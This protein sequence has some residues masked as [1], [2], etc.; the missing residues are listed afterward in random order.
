MSNT[1]L[2]Q[3]QNAF[4]ATVFAH[5]APASQDG[6]S[7]YRNNLVL[8]HQ[9]SLMSVFPHTTELLAD[10]FKAA[11]YRYLN[12]YGKVH[13][14]WAEI[15]ADFAEFLTQQP[16]LQRYPYISDLAQYEWLFHQANRAPRKVLQQRSIELLQQQDWQTLYLDLAPG[17]GLCSSDF[18]VVAMTDTH[19]YEAHFTP[20]PDPLMW[21]CWRPAL[22]PRSERI[23]AQWHLLYQSAASASLAQLAEI[24]RINQLDWLV[25]LEHLMRQ[26]QLFGVFQHQSITQQES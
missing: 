13:F 22:A 25:W 4:I 7:I 20:L 15:G 11:A 12:E 19:S 10:G 17:F 26:Q 14:D 1:D 5:N 3:W 23:A 8:T 6:M 9:A 2:A 24:G 21:V 16:E 18:D